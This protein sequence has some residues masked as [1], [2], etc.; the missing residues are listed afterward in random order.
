M[1]PAAG[2]WKHRAAGFGF[3]MEEKNEVQAMY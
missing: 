1:A 2:V 3:R